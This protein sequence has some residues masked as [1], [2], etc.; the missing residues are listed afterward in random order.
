[1]YGKGEGTDD[2]QKPTYTAILQLH[3]RQKPEEGLR[4]KMGQIGI[5]AKVGGERS[6]LRRVRGATIR[7][8]VAYG[9]LVDAT[10]AARGKAGKYSRNVKCDERIWID[11][12][13]YRCTSSGLR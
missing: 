12:W 5:L 8:S 4:A 2:T 6:R 3:K 9:E 7:A 13:R 1:M 11:Y 10:V